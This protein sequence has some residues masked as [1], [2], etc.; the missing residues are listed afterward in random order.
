MLKDVIMWV[1]SKLFKTPTQTTLKEV[2]DASIYAKDY[3]NKDRINFNAIFSNKLAN[4]TIVDSTMSIIGD[5]KR[6]KLLDQI[7]SSMWKK[8]KKITAM[9]YG[10]GGIAIVPYVKGG[11]LFYNIV[12]QD[13]ITFDK[14]E[15]EKITGATIR[16]EKKVIGG[17]IHETTYIRWTNYNVANNVITIKQQ[18]TDEKGNAIPKPEFWNDIADEI[19]FTGVDR[20]LFGFI[21]SPINNRTTNDKYGVPVTYGCK[22]TINEIYE[23]IDEIQREYKL[24]ETFVGAD[25]TMFDGKNSLPK[26]GLFRKIDAGDDNFFEVF[27]PQFRDY[28]TRLEELYVR[29]E[30]Q[31][32]TS[33]GILS[34]IETNNATATEIKRAS[35]DTFTIVDDMRTNIEKAMEDFYYACNVLANIYNLAPQGDYEV[36]YDWSYSLFADSQEEFSQLTAGVNQGVIEKAELRNWL[37]PSETMEESQEKIDEIKKNNPSMDDLLG[38]E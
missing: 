20:C 27:D 1:V 28:T 10:Y 37:K 31:V 13:R 6:A 2:N 25:V 4:Y 8:M 19:K 12:P 33:G 29:L 26:N 38:G 21:I 24:K 7:G 23:T 11:K 32:G 9:G 3:Q 17:T 15:G 36:N 35:Y 16:A 18:Y 14:I 5:N 22:D 30:H 34:K